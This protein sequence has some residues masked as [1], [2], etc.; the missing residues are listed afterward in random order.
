[1]AYARGEV[2]NP[3]KDYTQLCDHFAAWCYGWGGS[4]HYSARVHFY[5]IAARFR[6]KVTDPQ[7]VTP[8]SLVFWPEIGNHGHVTVAGN[9]PGQVFSNDIRRRGKIDRVPIS[10]ITTRWSAGQAWWTPPAF[11]AAFG[12]NPNRAPDPGN[13]FKPVGNGVELRHAALKAGAKGADVIALQW[14][15]RRQGYAGLNPTGITGLFGSETKAM[16]KRAQSAAKLPESGR[17]QVSLLRML[18]FEPVATTAAASSRRR[19]RR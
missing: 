16:V 19:S 1:M 4:G 10:E 9:V 11:P 12:R 8:G 14:A 3:D 13:P 6:R 2:D 15:L 7:E 18:G 5:A 17:P